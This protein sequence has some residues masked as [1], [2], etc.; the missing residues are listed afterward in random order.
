MNLSGAWAS[1]N[2]GPSLQISSLIEPGADRQEAR[3]GEPKAKP[4]AKKH[5]QSVA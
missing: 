3:Q 4:S 1:W 5:V 2:L